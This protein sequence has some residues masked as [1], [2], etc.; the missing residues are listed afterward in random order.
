MFT[1]KIKFTKYVKKIFFDFGK[2]SVF[3]FVNNKYG[4]NYTYFI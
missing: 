4:Q 1:E 2:F 3:F